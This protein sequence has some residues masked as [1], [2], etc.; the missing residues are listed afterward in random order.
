MPYRATRS[1]SDKAPWLEDI[2]R[3]F[4]TV[5]YKMAATVTTMRIPSSARGRW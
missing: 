2:Q 4:A 3:F 5:Q 1:A